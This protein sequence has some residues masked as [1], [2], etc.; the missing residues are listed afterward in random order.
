MSGDIELYQQLGG[1]SKGV[2]AMEK[3]IE[4][5]VSEVRQLRAEVS[6]L[7]L[8]E[9]QRGAVERASIWIA[10][11]LGAGIAMLAEHFWK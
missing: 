11:V 9:A 8:K 3:T 6:D 1:L 5:L 2:E 4:E 10:G 7:K